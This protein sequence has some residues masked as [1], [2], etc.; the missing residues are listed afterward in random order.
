[1]NFLLFLFYIYLSLGIVA[2]VVSI[3]TARKILRSPRL[4]RDFSRNMSQSKFD[5][6]IIKPAKAD[7][8]AFLIELYVSV[9]KGKW[10]LAF[11][12]AYQI[13]TMQRGYAKLLQ[14]R[15]RQLANA[16]YRRYLKSL[17]A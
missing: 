8:F 10:P 14:C 15:K 2:T 5:I 7:N 1:M 12:F 4:Y 3:Q 6:A 13:F 17:G 16:R 11:K 9:V